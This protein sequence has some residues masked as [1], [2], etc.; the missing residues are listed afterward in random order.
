MK[1][2]LFASLFILAFTASYAVAQDQPK[3]SFAVIGGANLQNLTGKAYNGDKL[4]N[5]MLLGYHIGFNAR[6]PITSNCFFQPGL[7]F[8]IKGFKNKSELSTSTTKLNYIEMPLN[9]GYKT[10][11]GNGTVVFGFGPYVAYAFGGKQTT[12][13]SSPTVEDNIEFKNVVEEIEPGVYEPG[14]FLKPLDAGA[15]LFA[16]YEMASGIFVQLNAQLG[17]LNIWPEYKGLSG[18]K[19]SEKNT[20]FGLS[21]GYRF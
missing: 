14:V 6:I 5:D 13:G 2:I 8:A 3:I 17:L 21:T 18:D 10:S 19:T 15:N 16:G 4:N 1:N 9:M 7:Q 11:L 12:K 20:G